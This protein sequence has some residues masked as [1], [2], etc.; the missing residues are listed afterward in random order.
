M[1]EK[2]MVSVYAKQEIESAKII[3]HNMKESTKHD[4]RMI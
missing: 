3:H 4:Q 1:D 2:I